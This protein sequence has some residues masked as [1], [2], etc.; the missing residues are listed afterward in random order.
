MPFVL[1]SSNLEVPCAMHR[2]YIL[3]VHGVL[4]TL[5]ASRKLSFTWSWYDTTVPTGSRTGSKILSKFLFVLGSFYFVCVPSLQFVSRMWHFSSQPHRAWSN[6]VLKKE[7]AADDENGVC[8]VRKCRKRRTAWYVQARRT[9]T[10]HMYWTM[11]TQRRVLIFSTHQYYAGSIS[12]WIYRLPSYI[13]IYVKKGCS[14]GRIENPTCLILA[15]T[16]AQLASSWQSAR[17]RPKPKDLIPF[18][19]RLHP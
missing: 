6:Q 8:V 16:M 7:D 4:H 9:L 14:S 5:A 2:W 17:T 19:V 18:H 3:G 10:T 13:Y 12:L 15:F 1:Y 11:M